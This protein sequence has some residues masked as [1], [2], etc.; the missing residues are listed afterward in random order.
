MVDTNPIAPRDQKAVRNQ[1]P[2]NSHSRL[3][4]KMKT[5]C[6]RL[7]LASFW[8]FVVKSWIVFLAFVSIVTVF[9]VLS[10]YQV[11]TRIASHDI[12]KDYRLTIWQLW[13]LNDQS[14][15]KTDRDEGP[16]EKDAVRN[17]TA[18]DF[19]TIRSPFGVLKF[20]NQ[21]RYFSQQSATRISR[22]NELKDQVEKDETAL[23]KKESDL[24][25]QEFDLRS[26]LM[27]KVPESGRAQ[28]FPDELQ[29]AENSKNRDSFNLA[30]KKALEQYRAILPKLSSAD[31]EIALQEDLQKALL[32]KMRLESSLRIQ[33]KQLYELQHQNIKQ[34]ELDND[35]M[36]GLAR[37]VT[38]NSSLEPAE[39][40]TILDLLSE[41]DVFHK[42]FYAFPLG[43]DLFYAP[44]ELLT[45]LITVAGGILGSIVLIG[46]DVFF[47]HNAR[48][49][50]ML[51][52]LFGGLVAL[53]FFIV[54]KA[55]VIVAI[56][57]RTNGPDS[58]DFNPFFVMFLGVVAGLLTNQVVEKVQSSAQTF[59]QTGG[60]ARQRYFI[61]NAEQISED[62]RKMLARQLGIS[63]GDMSNVLAGRQQVDVYAQK[64]IADSLEASVQKTFTDI[65]PS[66]TDTE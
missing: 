45:M 46:Y 60:V 66:E 29:W 22:I 39:L 64:L 20:K 12:G 35:N 2:Q 17:T 53:V 24:R 50:G 8:P 32:E 38:G 31:S 44:S 63:D 16:E 11:R 40:P 56:D 57:P 41:I 48:Q 36:I 6:E 34:V 47:N 42:I 4:D 13:R 28:A 10:A 52:P 54:V 23:F 30:L 26:R 27:Q 65:K 37:I 58:G 51:I 49:P 25:D 43:Q 1:A 7:T 55:G 3:R 5:I 21:A 33:R 62:N 19:F 9:F 18:P 15:H 61:G 14:E 59:L